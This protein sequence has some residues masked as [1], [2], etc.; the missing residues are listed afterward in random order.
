MQRCAGITASLALAVS[1]IGVPA[2]G[3]SLLVDLMTRHGVPL[4]GGSFE[5]AFDEGMAP[6]TPVTPG[7]VATPL[8]MLSSTTG[9]DRIAAAFA[10]G[11]LAG[12]AGRAASPEELNAAGVCL[13]EMLGAADR[14]TRIAAARVAGRIFTVPFD[15]RVFTPVPA[16]LVEALF[17]LLNRETEPEQLA[18]MDALGRL[19]HTAATT[20]LTERYYFYRDSRKR[21]LAGGALEALARIGD[22]SAIDI[23]KRLTTDPFSEGRDAT[24]LA[25]AFARERMLGDGSIA[26]IRQALD[27]RSLRWQAQGYLAE[28]GVSA[29]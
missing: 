28:L 3:Q 23:V 15:A 13:V 22:A 17:T 6:A 24:A 14:R 29:P 4:P 9:N 11:I 7:A 18:A 27:D 8:A 20:S 19:R 21:A 2:S 1:A 10:F 12:R 26:I 5:R 16:G 25:V